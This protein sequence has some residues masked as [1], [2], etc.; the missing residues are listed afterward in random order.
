V[1]ERPTPGT[2][3]PAPRAR[4]QASSAWLAIIALGA[5]GACAKGPLVTRPMPGQEVVTLLPDAPGE[6]PGRALVWTQQTQTL[7]MALDEP[8]STTIVT[9]NPLPAPPRTMS[10]AE[11]QQ[12]FGDALTALPTA[13]RSFQLYFLFDSDVLTD[14]SRALLPQ[15]LQTVQGRRGVEVAVVGHTD[16]SGTP[17][18]NYDL[19]L[20]RAQTTRDILVAAGF[21]PALIEVSS[22]GEGD[23]LVATPDETLEPRNRRVEVTIR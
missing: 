22:H 13:P 14:E 19:G 4:R 20:R 11:M 1:I 2:P 17:A 21:D 23:P 18:S 6:P 15:I 12:L 9:G 16:T 3:Q 7:A 5:T 8:R 10:E